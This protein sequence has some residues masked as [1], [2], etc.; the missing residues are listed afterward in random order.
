MGSV[1]SNDSFIV[2]CSSNYLT[3]LRR[4]NKYVPAYSFLVP[5]ADL[6][7]LFL[8]AVRRLL[9]KILYIF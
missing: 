4:C 9:S 2:Y 7:C 5:V 8:Y 1:V 3:L 6:D